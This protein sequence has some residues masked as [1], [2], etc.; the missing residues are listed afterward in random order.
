[1]PE[2]VIQQSQF[3]SNKACQ[4]SI[5]AIEE[6]YDYVDEINYFGNLVNFST[7]KGEPYQRWVRYREGYSTVLVNELIKRANLDRDNYY[8]ADPMVGS[9]TTMITAAENGYDSLGLDVNPYCQLIVSTKMLSPQKKDLDSI[10]RFVDS[11]PEKF[12]STEIE[13]PP[14][15]D[16]FPEENLINILELRKKIDEEREGVP[17]QI[18]LASWFFILEDCSNR[19]KDG[20][21]LATRPAPIKDVIAHYKAMLSKIEKD[22]TEVP[23][24]VKTKSMVITESATNFSKHSLY[25]ENITGKKLGAIVFSPPYANAFDYYESYK[26]ELLFGRLYNS[27]DFQVHKKKQ[28]RNYRIS[29]GKEIHCEY[30][31]VETLCAAV[32]EAIPQKEKI[33]GKRDARTRLMPNMLRGY[34]TDMGNVLKELY[35]SLDEGGHCF[36][37]VDQSAYVGVIIPTDVLLAN[38]AE[39]IGFKV[40]R[41]IICRKAATSGQQRKAYPYLSSTLRESIVWLTK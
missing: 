14:L 9:G 7:A 8:I 29:Y 36:I 26:M 15:S 27:E 22:Y 4:E 12:T 20:N 2:L 19:K 41:I 31:V 3:Y 35:T 11:L 25:F 21:G 40:K 37:V 34:F 23:F 28:I 6:R 18:L 33:T 38:I 10:H 32:N 13:R 30:P 5:K 17:K 24:E 16:Y 1:M 39:L